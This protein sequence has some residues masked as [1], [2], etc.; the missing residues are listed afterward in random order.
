MHQEGSSARSGGGLRLDAKTPPQGAT[1]A[2]DLTAKPGKEQN[3]RIF[4][5]VAVATAIL[6]LV[7]SPASSASLTAAEAANHLGE[8]ATVCG[9]VASAH[10]ASTSKARPT[11]INLDKPYPNQV[12][13]AVIF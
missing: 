8:T 1:I 9:Q 4:G 11:F 2:S 6:F 13:T 7:S 12:F 10:Y 5:S 3:M